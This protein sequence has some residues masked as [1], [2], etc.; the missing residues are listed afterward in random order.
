MGWARERPHAARGG[1]ETG[2]QWLTPN[3]EVG[4]RADVVYVARCDRSA[5]DACSRE[6]AHATCRMT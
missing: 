6:V 4:P 2:A 3:V 1:A 5:A